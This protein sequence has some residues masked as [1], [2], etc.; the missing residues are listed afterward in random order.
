MLDVSIVN[1]AL[2]SIERALDAG[3]TELQL[4]VAGYT[5]AFGLSLVPAGRLGDAGVAARCS[6]RGSW[7]LR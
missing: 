7:D 6:S 3:P 1:V 4:I 2:P 5:L